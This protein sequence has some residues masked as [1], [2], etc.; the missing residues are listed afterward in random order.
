[1][2]SVGLIIVVIALVFL[3]VG[4][5]YFLGTRSNRS[6]GVPELESGL[7]SLSDAIDRITSSVSAQQISSA[8]SSAALRAELTQSLAHQS[9]SL[10][11]S[12]SEVKTQAQQLSSV[13]SRSGAQ[14]GRQ[15]IR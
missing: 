9:E 2:E 11:R 1:M 8:Q 13:L 14:A 5:G 15:R 10:L 6:S 3:G 12:V 7:N 4:C